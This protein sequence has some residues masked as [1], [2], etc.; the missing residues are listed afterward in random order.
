[1][2]GPQGT[3]SKLTLYFRSHP[4]VWP[5]TEA[6]SD[7]PHLT[8]LPCLPAPNNKRYGESP[9]CQAGL[10]IMG[11]LTGIRQGPPLGSPEDRSPASRAGSLRNLFSN[12]PAPGLQEQVLSPHP[13]PPGPQMARCRPQGAQQPQ[14]LGAWEGCQGS[15]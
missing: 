5:L 6:F 9:P 13:P 2:A 3:L 8:A 10:G 14:E 11:R 4:Q 12:F 15:D 1:M 7:T